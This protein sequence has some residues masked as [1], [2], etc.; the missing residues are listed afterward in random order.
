MCIHT[1]TLTAGKG[2]ALKVYN[3]IVSPAL[4]AIKAEVITL[5]T[6]HKFHA[7]EYVKAMSASE[8][9]A[10]DCIFVMGGDGMI[11]EVLHGL[12]NV[13]PIGVEDVAGGSG[14]STTEEERIARKEAASRVSVSALP[15]GSANGLVASI[16]HEGSHPLGVSAHV[17]FPTFAVHNT[18]CCMS[19]SAVELWVSMFVMIWS[20]ALH[21]I[22]LSI[23]LCVLL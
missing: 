4:E 7:N 5:R 2:V 23:P 16:N 22:C 8:L 14:E 11:S 15:C 19:V 10:L 3:T 12:K 1:Y 17:V 13:P 9:A 21:A 20:S 6:T 18:P